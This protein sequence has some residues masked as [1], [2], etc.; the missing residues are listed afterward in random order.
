MYGR[1][2]KSLIMISWMVFAALLFAGCVGDD[3][4]C[5]SS[6]DDLVIDDDIGD[7]DTGD[8]DI[9]DDDLADD[10]VVDD[11]VVDDDVVDDD[12][13]DDDV[14]D[15]DVVDDD[16]V[17]DDVVDDDVVD[18]DV[19]DDDVV[20]DDVV[21][22]D[23]VDDDTVGEILI[24][25]IDGGAPGFDG[26]Y[27]LIGP[28]NT[29]YIAAVIDRHIDLLSSAADGSKVWRTIVPYGAYPA[30]A[31]D[32]DG[33]LHLSYID[34]DH[35]YLSYATNGSGQWQRE[36]VLDSMGMIQNTAIA[37]D[38]QGFAHIS[39]YGLGGTRH[40][41]N[42]SGEW[43]TELV[44]GG[45]KDTPVSSIG[46]D[47][48]GYVHVALGGG[49]TT[50]YCNNKEGSWVCHQLGRVTRQ[51]GQRFMVLDED[52]NAHIA[53]HDL[54][55]RDALIYATNAS[56]EWVEEI[57]DDTYCFGYPTSMALD[58]EGHVYI[59]YAYYCGTRELRLVTNKSGSWQWEQ[60][61]DIVASYGWQYTLAVDSAQQPHIAV[62][63]RYDDGLVHL[64]KVSGT[65]QKTIHAAAPRVEEKTSLCFD[66]AGNA[67]TAYFDYWNSHIRYAHGRI[68]AWVSE[69]IEILETLRG[70]I[71][72]AL[73]AN[74]QPHFFYI[75]W[76]QGFAHTYRQG[77]AWHHEIVMGGNHD[78]GIGN[79]VRLDEDGFFHI[80]MLDREHELVYYLTNKSGDW[81]H[82]PIDFSFVYFN[83]TDLAL[84]DAGAAHICYGRAD[85]LR[86]A[87][88]KSGSWEYATV[89]G[90]FAMDY[91]TIALD[92]AGNVYIA[93]YAYGANDLKLATN[94][95]GEWTTRVIDAT[96]DVGEFN[97]I[98]VD[99][100]GAINIVYYD[101]TNADLKY[102]TNQSG[103]WTTV[104]LDQGGEIGDY[105]SLESC[106]GLLHS[107]YMGEHAI[108]YA[109]FPPGIGGE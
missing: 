35:G 27:L 86:Y 97:D 57:A 45:E 69:E 87:T 16:V 26:T 24:D 93:Y 5:G 25:Q 74:D 43:V 51:A 52:G 19:V 33:F 48:Q 14:V 66:A 99:E 1:V 41:T 59:A 9:Y 47:D 79:A 40:L 101:S 31:L 62:R 23:A 32:D 104:I 54:H 28:G 20:D 37:V 2:F 82:T 81:V 53:F 38:S 60:L 10:D 29:I 17:D 75:V 84:D 67:H 65:W 106:D 30:M 50:H 94:A 11:D 36:N 55:D 109:V 71:T 12:V 89:D 34:T 6:D 92:E 77:G 83:M 98:V 44:A 88:N 107:T 70:E 58:D 56:G 100:S 18:D 49:S 8:D 108:W 46:V 102:A 95:S 61:T 7:D 91:Q 80:S 96:G 78:M 42:E 90:N 103:D 39:Y 21:D 68:G 76:L 85:K 3:D 13:V 22:D 73:D 72:L 15:D 63:S 64:K 105:L 4:D